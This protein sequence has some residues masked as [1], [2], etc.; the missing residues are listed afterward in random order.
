M[1]RTHQP[2]PMFQYCKCGGLAEMRRRQADNGADHVG[3]HCADCDRWASFYGKKWLPHAMLRDAGVIIDDL[4]YARMG[5]LAECVRCGQMEL[6]ETHHFAPRKCFDDPDKW[7]T[8]ML[9]VPCHEEW[10]YKM[11]MPIRGNIGPVDD[12]EEL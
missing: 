1:T 9:C 7:P 12:A 5:E 10:H 3:Y 4:D 2:V 8:A 11:G 6:C